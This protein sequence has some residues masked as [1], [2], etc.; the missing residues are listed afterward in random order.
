MVRWILRFTEPNGTLDTS[1][2]LNGI[3]IHDLGGHGVLSEAYDLTLLDDGKIV[4]TGYTHLPFSAVILQCLPDGTLDP[5]FGSQG[6]HH[7]LNEVEGTSLVVRPDGKIIS[8]IMGGGSNPAL[9]LVQVLPDGSRD[10]SFGVG[11]EWK[12]GL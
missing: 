6:V 11:H 7:V 8:A 12:K 3:I 2:G 5:A 10:L 9:T 4:V 1:F